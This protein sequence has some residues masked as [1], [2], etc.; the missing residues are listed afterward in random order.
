MLCDMNYENF[1][2]NVFSLFQLLKRLNDNNNL[3]YAFFFRGYIFG[4]I[5]RLFAKQSPQ[6]FGYFR[7]P[8][9]FHLY[10]GNSKMKSIGIHKMK[11]ASVY[12]LHLNQAWLIWTFW[13]MVHNLFLFG[14]SETT[15]P[16]KFG[17]FHYVYNAVIWRKKRTIDFVP[18]IKGDKVPEGL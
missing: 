5:M 11:T 7:I 10:G 13:L 6:I 4:L 18:A 1:Q 12:I 16:S 9:F 14:E 15:K 3:C 2:E 8:I 17:F